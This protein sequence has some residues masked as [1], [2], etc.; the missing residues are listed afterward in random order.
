MKHCWKCSL[1]KPKIDFGIN[2]SKPDGLSTEC[3]PCKRQQDREYAA[4]NREAAKQRASEWYYNNY[5]YA[6]QR[7]RVN[8]ERWRKE[9]PDKH[10]ARQN[11]RRA[12]KLNA[13]PTWLTESHNLHIQCKY[14]LAKMLSRETGIQHHVDHIVPLKG[15]TV[16]GLH[17]PWNLRVIPAIDNLRKSNKI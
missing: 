13:T 1:S 8:G 4:Q 9:N 2:K 12:S 15:K 10:C 6:L 7:N 16:C 17:V 11:R 14:S 3:K 5:N